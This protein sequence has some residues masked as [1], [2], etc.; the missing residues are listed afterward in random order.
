MSSQETPVTAVEDILDQDSLLRQAEM[1]TG[2]ANWGPN[3]HFRVG[4]GKLI[5]ATE[6]MAPSPEFRANVYN[7][8]LQILSMKLHMVDDELRHPEIL[9]GKVEKPL[10]V[11]GLPRTGTTILY[12]LLSLDPKS[13]APREWETFMPWPAPEI[14]TF[15][16]DPRIDMINAMYAKMLEK[17][18][19][20][21]DIQRLD[22]TRPGECNHIMTHHFASTNFAAELA[23][24]AYGEWFN[25]TRVPG[26]YVSHK[27]ILQQLQ[28]KGPRGN[29]LL[30]SPVHLF[31]L[32]GL[33]ETYPDAQLVWTHRDPVLTLSSI[34]S[35]VH[36]LIKSQGVDVP[37][38]VVGMAQWTTWTVGLATGTSSRENSPVVENAILDL[39]HRDIVTDPVGAI[40]KVYD[41]FGREFTTEHAERID[42]FIHNNPAA[43]RIG[44]HKHSPEEYGLSADEIHNKLADYYRRFGKYCARAD[45]TGENI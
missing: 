24:P 38:E 4:L 8:I 31:D 29:W 43:S 39:A 44:K 28:W 10:V 32:E 13:R 16:T 33:L 2:L 7:R 23:V 34:S 22:A 3:P 9:Q 26:Q 40:R 41:Q 11:I 17:S 30:K 45:V 6:S 5:D 21:A 1:I 35:M 19:E 15:D 36:A 18:P 37:K 27:R 14:A 12:D 42:E 25:H 20:L